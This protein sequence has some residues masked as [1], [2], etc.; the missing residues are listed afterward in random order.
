MTN[1]GRLA[2]RIQERIKQHQED[3][4][5]KQ[6]Q[7][8][9]RMKALLSQRERFDNTARRILAS[10][11]LPR[12]QELSSHFDNATVL[13]LDER[14]DISCTCQFPHSARFPATVTF[15]IAFFPGDN[16]KN[17]DVHSSLEILPMLMEYKRNDERSFSVDTYDEEAIGLWVEEK[18]LDFVEIY[19]QLQTHPLYQK[20]NIVTDP[21]CG[22]QISAIEATSKLEWSGR[23][24]YFCSEVCKDAFSK[25]DK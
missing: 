4:Q 5:Q 15:S 2:G 20:E 6:L 14:A 9:I 22:M 21:V 25:K 3:T 10:V 13:P 24:I 11:V 8:D 18:I 16:Y 12:I 7:T 1:M 17:L 23:T 19:L